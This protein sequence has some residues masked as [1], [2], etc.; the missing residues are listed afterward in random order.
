[1]VVV[2]AIQNEVVG[3]FAVTVYIRTSAVS[4]GEP[5]FKRGQ[6]RVNRTRREQR[7]FHIVAGGQRQGGIG[8]RV[9]HLP[10]QVCCVCRTGAA[11]VTSTVV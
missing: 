9:D 6:I 4:G 10:D 7:Q 1:M 3:L 11:E 5:V 2:H 8:S